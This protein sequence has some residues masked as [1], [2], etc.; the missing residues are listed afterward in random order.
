MDSYNNLDLKRTVVR[1]KSHF[2]RSHTAHHSSIYMTFQKRHD[3]YIPI[4]AAAKDRTWG[5]GMTTEY[6]ENFSG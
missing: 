3:Y 4:P 1:S 5:E 6:L 2:E